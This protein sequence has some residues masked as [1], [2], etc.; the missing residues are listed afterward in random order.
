MEQPY[1][2][3][4][5]VCFKDFEANIRTGELRKRGRRVRV[6]EQPFQIL[7]M[8]LERPGDLVTREELQKRLWPADTFVELDLSLNAAVKKLRQAL[9][10]DAENPRY[11]ETLPR[12]GYR[13]IA[14]VDGGTADPLSL[15]RAG[16]D[17]EM[18]RRGLPSCRPSSPG[19]AV[20]AQ[21]GNP[22]AVPLVPLQPSPGGVREPPLR[23]RW[24]LRLAALLAM[25]LVGLS[26][27]WFATHRLPPRP[28]PKP[29]RLTANPAGNP[30]THA[31]ISPDGKY[32]AYADQRGHPFTVDR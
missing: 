23:S 5:V 20:P 25:G 27:A 13:F 7:T 10:D 8:L 28:E 29:R 31:H 17:T 26:V 30:A 22:E 4:R 18:V 15:I 21:Q 32:L 12:R 3:G 9:G 2:F 11:I 1:R 6:S 24:D 14:P 16:L 19:E